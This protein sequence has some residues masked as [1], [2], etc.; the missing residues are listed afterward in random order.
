MMRGLLSSRVGLLSL[1]PAAA[2]QQRDMRAPGVSV[3]H[4]FSTKPGE[5]HPDRKQLLGCKRVVIK[6]GTAVVS[7]SDG[8]LALSRMGALVEE[9]ANL[10]RQGKQVMLISS[11]AVGL[12]RERVGLSKEVVSNVK[13]VVERQACAAAGQELLM[14]TYNMM[15]SRLKLKCAQVLIT[16]SDFSNRER[17][18]YLSSTLKRLTELGVIPV[19]NENDVVTGSS[20]L[21]PS[22]A[23][24]VFADNDTLAALI[25]ASAQADAVLM[26]TDVDAVFTKPP[27]TPGAERIAV[28]SDTTEFEEGA[29]ST[30]GRGGMGSKI[31]AARKAASSGANCVIANGIYIPNITKVF[32]GEDIGTLFPS[33]PVTLSPKGFWLSNM[34]IPSGVVRLKHETAQ[35]LKKSRA[36]GDFTLDISS[37]VECEGDFNKGTV[38]AL[39]DAERRKC[40]G[41]AITQDGSDEIQATLRM[42]GQGSKLTFGS[43]KL[44]A[45]SDD[46]V[47]HL[48]ERD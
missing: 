37:I 30:M 47:M 28:Y 24:Q 22:T 3:A 26:M 41:R 38:I 5:A 11:G 15:F 36:S 44:L 21:D 39:H 42:V 45:K 46:I 4:N 34:A 20:Q 43:S 13:N 18:T 17:Y 7:S 23:G 48:E 19:I 14:S 9:I 35:A 1:L 8:S 29:K 12:G 10:T 16:Q 2:R 31:G 40:I 33:P 27:G 6:V 25:G 32:N